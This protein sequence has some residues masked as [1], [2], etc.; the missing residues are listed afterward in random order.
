MFAVDYLQVNRGG[1]SLSTL[2]NALEK[3]KMPAPS[4]PSTSLGFNHTTGEDDDNEDPPAFTLSTEPDQGGSSLQHNFSRRRSLSV[5]HD[6]PRVLRKTSVP[7]G[8]P[9]TSRPKPSGTKTHLVQKSMTSFFSKPNSSTSTSNPRSVKNQ[10][11]GTS[12]ITLNSAGAKANHRGPFIVKGLGGGGKVFPMANKR[13]VHKV[14]KKT[15][16]PMVEAS[17]IKGGGGGGADESIVVDGLIMTDLAGP[18]AKE[19]TTSEDLGDVFM[20]PLAKEGDRMQTAEGSGSGE[21]PKDKG[22]EK[23]KDEDKKDLSRRASLALSQLSHS[24]SAAPAYGIGDKERMGP[25]ATPR[26]I[27]RSASSSYPAPS[28]VIAASN[29][30]ITTAN[31]TASLRSSSSPDK[32]PTPTGTR[33]SARQAAK[34]AA[35]ADSSSPASSTGAGGSGKKAKGAPASANKAESLKILNNCVIFVDVRA[36][37]GEE[38]GSLF[39]EMLEGLGAK[40][41]HFGSY[42]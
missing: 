26:K 14:S 4:R 33:S 25:P 11:L 31:S 22:K 19:G 8:P 18:S 23:V 12:K 42:I 30:T 10:L 37:D 7:S 5:D 6:A 35:N 38:A 27:A 40:A 29:T 15:S 3:L 20:V 34:A 17:P 36:D 28:S 41:S 13:L 21:K 32:I 9:S 24:I 16:L 39:V 1:S 2:S